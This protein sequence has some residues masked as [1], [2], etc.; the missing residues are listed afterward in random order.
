MK[1]V[2]SALGGIILLLVIVLAIANRTP[3]DFSLDAFNPDNPAVVITLPLFLLVFIA[4]L[5]GMAVGVSLGWLS[6][7]Q[8]RNSVAQAELVYPI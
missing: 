1:Y 8:N 2:R 4:L 5:I 7:T 3:V 6:Q